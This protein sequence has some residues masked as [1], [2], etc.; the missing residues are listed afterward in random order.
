M[1][2]LLTGVPQGS[3]LVPLLFLIYINDVPNE[4]KTNAK[5]FADDTS[6]FTIVKDINESVNALNNELSLISK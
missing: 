6:L 4:L 5:H 2:K 1:S 3:I